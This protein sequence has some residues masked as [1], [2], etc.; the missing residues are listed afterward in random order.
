MIDFVDLKARLEV[1]SGLEKSQLGHR[2][3]QHLIEEM[4]G[5]AVERQKLVPVTFGLLVEL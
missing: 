3:P 4:Q 5:E 2:M 1:E